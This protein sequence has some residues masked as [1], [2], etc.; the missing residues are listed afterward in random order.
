[1]ALVPSFT[2]S[3]LFT[4]MLLQVFHNNN[5][6]TVVHCDTF[7]LC[8]TNIFIIERVFHDHCFVLSRLRPSLYVHFTGCSLTLCVSSGHRVVLFSEKKKYGKCVFDCR[9][10]FLHYT[11]SLL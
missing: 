11:H 6:E 10:Y 4:S 2:G 1:M 9:S 7:G 8:D 3:L 5:N